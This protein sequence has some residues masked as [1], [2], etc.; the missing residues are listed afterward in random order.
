MRELLLDLADRLTAFPVGTKVDVVEV[1]NDKVWTVRPVTVLRDD[2]EE[3]ALWL[4]PGTV[5]RYPVGPQHGEHTV[6][7]WL[8]GSWELADRVWDPPGLLR[9]S[10]PGDS[11]EVWRSLGEQKP[12]YVNLQEPMRRVQAGFVTMDQVLDLLVAANLGEWQWKDETEFAYAQQAGLFSAEKAAEIRGVGLRVIE[13]VKI[14]RPPWD[15][16]WASWVPE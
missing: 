1:L 6:N 13:A 10:R 16:N 11:F 3:V 14:G 7:Q 15:P 9:L 8:S 12:W 5:T 2:P 4:E